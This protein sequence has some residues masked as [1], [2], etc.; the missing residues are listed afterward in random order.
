MDKICLLEQE[1][2]NNFIFGQVNHQK[3][4]DHVEDVVDFIVKSNNLQFVKRLS[5]LY[6][7]SDNVSIN[8]V[9]PYV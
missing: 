2:W 9:I 8:C 1:Q 4:E 5:D 6:Y 3:F 7:D